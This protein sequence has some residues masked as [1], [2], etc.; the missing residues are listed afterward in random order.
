MTIYATALYNDTYRGLVPAKLVSFS[1]TRSGSKVIRYRWTIEAGSI[2]LNSFP[3][4]SRA[5]TA[6][7]RYPNTQFSNVQSIDN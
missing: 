3:T 6:A 4:I 1:T 5:I 7:S 2:N